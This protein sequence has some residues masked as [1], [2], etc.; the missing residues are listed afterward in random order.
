MLSVRCS[1]ATTAASGSSS[2]VVDAMTK[3]ALRKIDAM[4]PPP[5]LPPLMLQTCRCP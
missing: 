4:P 3:Y 1:M 2:R 5:S